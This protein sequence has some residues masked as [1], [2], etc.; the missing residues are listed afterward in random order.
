M[1]QTKDIR[2]IKAAIFDL[3][4]TLLDSSQIL[5]GLGERFLS[6]RGMIQQREL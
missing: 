6:R 5:D 4:G 2:D 3:D 1:N